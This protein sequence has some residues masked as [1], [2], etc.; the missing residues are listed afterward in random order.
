MLFD[1]HIDEMNK[2]VVGTLMF[3]NRMS[4]NLD[5]ESRIIVVQSLVLT[6]INYCI[7][8]WG[9]ANS[10]IL[11]RA[12]KL[13][14]FAAKVAHGGAR[15]YDHATPILQE[16]GWLK[17]KEKHRLD[18]CI[19]VYKIVES[20]YPP[21]F[22]TFPTVQSVTNSRTRQRN[23]LYVPRSKTD[24]GVR[25]MEV[26][27]PKLWNNLPADITTSATLSSFKAKV[28]NYLSSIT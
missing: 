13:Q 20:H 19:N 22:K 17:I 1:K 28:I 4:K 27:G 24:A 18:I 7:G 26:L 10:T 14:N 3:I 25:C 2:K 23:K 16:L 8:I 9:T 12:Q 6:I 15:K 5:K 21:W 11:K